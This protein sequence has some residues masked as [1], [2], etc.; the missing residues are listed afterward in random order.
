MAPSTNGIQGPRDLSI[1]NLD[2]RTLPGPQLLHELVAPPVADRLILDFLLS[3]GELVKL[4]YSCF[5]R[6]TDALARDIRA[7]LYREKKDKHV[8][9]VIIPQ[10][11]ELYIAWVAT[12]K[13]GAAFC[14]VSHDVPP[15]RLKF[16]VKDVD[17]SFVL[18]T[19]STLGRVQQLLPDEICMSLSFKE[20]SDRTPSG[21]SHGSALPAVRP[22][23]PAY[24]MYT[25]GS[26]GMPKGVMVS[27]L[28]VTQSL[29]AHDEHIPHF[30]RFLQF[31]S[32]TFDVSIFEVFFPFFRGATLVGCD[33]ERML[34]DL[35]ATIRLLDADAA[36]LTPTVAGTLLRR[37]DAAPCLKTLLTIGEMLTP[38]VVSE[39][40]GSVDKP[41]M[42]YAMYGPTEAAIHCTLAPKL[43]SNASVRSI[44]QPLQSVTAFILKESD[45][46][47]V[48]AL[49]E[50]G[51]LAIAG[52]LADGYLNRPDQ[53]RVAF[54]ELPG[55]GPIH[56][57]GDRA[58]CRP[59][60]Q[61]E[62]LGRLASGQVKLRGQR[63]ELGE[64][65]EV[66]SRTPGVQLAIA[67]IIDDNLVLFCSTSHTI[68]ASEILATCKSWLP[69][70]MRPNEIVVLQEDIPRL[71]SGKVDRKTLER[72]FWRP[73]KTKEDNNFINDTERNIAQVL[74]DELARKVDRSTS[75][76]SLGL[77][78]LRA[79][80]IA[81][82]LRQKHRSINAAM[83]LEAENVADLADLIT[84]SPP[85]QG[86]FAAES[87]YEDSESWIAI[88]NSLRNSTELADLWPAWEKVVPCSTMQVAMLVETSG[89][90][91][92]NFNEICL[93]L[94]PDVSFDAFVRAFGIVAERNEILRSGFMAT[95]EQAMPFVHIIWR[96]IPQGDL[97]ML[98]PLQIELVSTPEKEE[99]L[100]RVHHA[101]Y[102]GWSWELVMDDLNAILSGADIPLRT[103]FSAFRSF[104]HSLFSADSTEHDEYWRRHFEGFVPSSFPNLC[105]TRPDTPSK[106][107]LLIPLSTSYDQ[108]SVT[109]STLRCSREAILE[110]AWSFVLSSYLD[111]QDV[112]IGVV[113]AG[114]HLPLLGVESVI[115]PC[116][117]TFPLRTDLNS[118]RTVRDLVSFVQRQ[119]TGCLNYGNT[120]LRNINHAAGVRS[121][122][123]L[124]DTLCVW[125]QTSE[126]HE[127]A[128]SKVATIR[129][130]DALDYA[131]V[132][133]FE[134][135]NESIRLKLT[136][137][138]SLVPVAH[139]KLLAN[140]L[141]Y[142]ANEMV[143]KHD[144]GLQELWEKAGQG[145]L[146]LSNVQPERFS[147][148][149]GLTTTIEHLAE[150][151]PHRL[152]VEF[153]HSFNPDTGHVNKESLTYSHL[154]EKAS[155]VASA[156]RSK[157][158]VGPDD[159][160]AFIAPRSIEL[161]IGILGAIM[162]GAGY[163]C[164][165]PRTPMERIGH[166]IG[167][168]ACRLVLTGECLEIE[169][170]NDVPTLSIERVVQ[171]PSAPFMPRRLEYTGDQLAYA[172]FTSGSTGVPKGV[173]ITR[174]NLLSNL[175]DLSRLYPCIPGED[176]LL[177]ACSP[178]FDVSV[179]EIFW[180][181]HMGMTLC[182]ASNDVLFK[183]LERFIHVLTITH[184]SMTPSVAALVNPDA[185]PRVKLLVTAGEP[186]NSRVFADWADRG[187]FQGYGPSETTNICTVRPNVTRSSASNNAG[188]PLPN[189]SVF[190]CRRQ[191]RSQTHVAGTATPGDPWMFSPV[192]K[193]GTGEIWIGGEQVGRG[194]IDPTL[195]AKAF[196]DH[197]RYGRLYR[198]GDIGRLLSDESITILGRDDDQVKLRGQR[199]ELGEINSCLIKYEDVE[200][201]VSLIVNDGHSAR[202]VAFWT[203]HDQAR[204]LPLAKVTKALFE[205][206]Q[207]MLPS[208]MIPD[209]L[210][211]LDSIPLTRQ[212]KIDRAAM[213]EAYQKLTPEQLQEFSKDHGSSEEE[214]D[215][216]EEERH[217]A[218]AISSALE[219]PPEAIRRNTSFFALGMDSISAIRVARSLRNH[220]PAVEISMLLRHPS[221]GQLVLALK[222]AAQVE[223]NKNLEASFDESLNSDWKATV[224]AT[225]LQAGLIVDRVLPC[226]PLQE[227]MAS[228]S[229]DSH[230]SAY[231]NSLR[232]RIFSDIS[233]MREA[234]VHAVSRHQLLRTG[235]AQTGSADTPFVQV[236][237]KDFPLPWK[238]EGDHV[239][240]APDLPFLMYPPWRMTLSQ[241]DGGHQELDLQIHHCLYDAEAMSILLTEIQ[242]LLLGQE[243]QPAV[244]F[245]NYLS[246]VLSAQSDEVDQYWRQKLRGYSPSRLGEL[247]K[248]ED[249]TPTNVT[250]VSVH[251]ATLNVVELQN[252]AR[253][254]CSTPLALLQV[255]WTRLLFCLFD[256]HDICFGNVMSGRNLPI[257]GVDRVVAPCFNTVPVRVQVQ[258]ETSNV[259]LCQYIQQKNVE[260]LPYQPSSLRRIQRQNS[261]DSK[262]LFDTLL[263]FQGEEL[264]L[265]QQI[266]TLVEESGDM[267]FPFILEILMHG[268]TD[269]I[270]LKLHSQSANENV[271]AQLLDCF[272]A[273][274]LHTTRYLNARALDYSAF[275]PA[276]PQLKPLNSSAHISDLED[277]MQNEQ[278]AH[279]RNELSHTEALVRDV[280][281]QLKPD[282]K[283]NITKDTSIFRLGFDSI[284]AVQIAARLRQQGYTISSA[285]IL[286]AVTIHEI[287]TICKLQ[288]EA[289]QIPV[290]FDLAAFDRR[291][292]QT[293]CQDNQI[294][295]ALV[296][297]IR[298]CTPTQSGILSQFLRS[299]GRLYFNRIVF[300]LED[301][302]DPRRLRDAWAAAQN[303]HDMLRTGFVETDDPRIPFAMVTYHAGTVPVPWT[304][305]TINGN[306]GHSANSV[307]TSR[308]REHPWQLRFLDGAL[309]ALELSMLHSLYDAK[310][311]DIILRDVAYIYA[312]GRPPNPIEL[313]PVISDIVARSRDEGSRE[314]WV[315]M[316]PD[317][318]PTRFPDLRIYTNNEEHFHVACQAS[319]VPREVAEHACHRAGASMQAVCASA[320]ALLLSAYTA[321]DH[322]TFGIILSG[323]NFQQEEQ[324]MV[325]FPCINTLPFAIQVSPDLPGLLQRTSKRC[326]GILRHQHTSA[327]SIKRWTGIQEELF[328]TVIVLQKFDR[329]TGPNRPWSLDND[330][331]TAEYAVSL[332]IIPKADDLNFQLTFKDS[333]VPP[334]QASQILCEFDALFRSILD[335]R[336]YEPD[337]DSLK[338]VV[339]AKEERI[340]T[341]VRF[342]H[343]LV[344]IAATHKPQSIALEFV[345]S[346]DGDQPDKASWTYSEL[347]SNGNR[348]G[349]LLQSKG[350][351]AGELVA[352]CFDK[353]P[354]ASF[355]ILG[356]LKAGCG[357][358]AIDPG[359]PRARKDF[360]L[361]DSSCAIVLTTGDKKSEFPGDKITV[362]ALDEGM[363]LKFP[364]E[365][366]VPSRKLDPQDTCY[367]LY[368]SGTTGTPKGCLI[369][370]D[371][372]VQAMLSFQRI[373]EG[374]W[375]ETSRWLQFASFHFD[376][377]VLEQFW[378]WSVGI[379]VTSAPRDLL[380]ED[381]PGFISALK[382]THL[383]LTPSLARL[384]TPEEVPSLC[385]GVFIVGGE[386]VRQ[387]ILETWGDTH[388]L[389]NFYG[390]SEVTIGCTVHPQVPKNAKPTNIGQQWDNVT[391]FVLRP[392]SQ[393]PVLRGAVGELCLSGPLVGK[394]YLNRPEL[395]AERFVTLA[396]YKTGVY[397]T[398][399]LVRL[400]HDNSFEFMGRIDDQVKLRGQRLEVAEINHVILS[401]GSTL[402]DAVTMVIKH[403][404]QQKDQLVTFFSTEKRRAKNERP[405]I[406]STKDTKE[407]AR[408]LQQR[409]ADMLPAYMVPTYFI[410]VSSIPLSV[411]NKVDHKALRGLFED[412]AKDVWS[413]VSGDH[414]G[415]E[416]EASRDA[417]EVTDILASFLKV[418]TT[419]ITPSSGL[420]ELGLDS[421]SV[422]GLSRTLR[423]HGFKT[424]DVATILKQPTVRDLAAAVHRKS[425]FD[426]GEAVASARD[427]IKS[428]GAAHRR[429]IIQALSVDDKDIENV[430][431]CT[432][433]QE[434]MMSKA[435]CSEPGDTVYFSSFHFELNDKVDLKRLEEAWKL[436]QQSI[437]ILRTHFVPTSRGVAQVVLRQTHSG[438]AL[439]TAPSSHKLPCFPPKS[440]F[441][442]W[443]GSVKGF[444]AA[445]P[446]IVELL[447]SAGKAYMILNIF[448]GLYDGIS[449]SLLLDV[450]SRIYNHGHKNLHV[451]MQFYQILPYGPLC[452]MPNEKEFWVSKLGN[453]QSF[454]LLLPPSETGNEAAPIYLTQSISNTSLEDFCK[455]LDITTS[456]F[457]QAWWLY[458]LQQRYN[459]NPLIGVVVSGRALTEV[460]AEDVIGPMFNTIPFAI[461]HLKKDSTVSDLIRACHQYNVDVVPYQHSPLRRVAKYL[462]C[463]G[464]NDMFNSLFVFQKP[465]IYGGQGF[466]WH[467]LP[468][469]ST[470]DYPLN[471]EVEQRGNTFSITLVAKSG[472]VSEAGARALLRTYVECLQ[473]V[474]AT[475]SV[476][477][478][479]FC[480]SRDEP[481]VSRQNAMMGQESDTELNGHAEEV[482]WTEAELAIR[483]EIAGLASVEKETIGLYKPTLFELGLDS[484]EAMK[485]A[486][487]LKNVGLKVAV[488]TIMR[489]P[490]VAG[491]ANEI[492]AAPGCLHEES[493]QHKTGFSI[494]ESQGKYRQILQDHGL[495]VDSVQRILPVTPMQEGLLLESSKY[496][497]VMVFQLKPGVDLSRLAVAWERVSELEP[498]LRTHFA[499][500]EE[501]ELP[502]AFLQ[503]V[504]TKHDAVEVILGSGLAQL[505]KSMESEAAREDLKDQKPRICILSDDEGK[506]F[507]V[508]AMSHALYDAW[509]MHLLHQQVTNLYHSSR[510]DEKRPTDVQYESYVQQVINQ[511]QS[512]V[513]QRFW[514]NQLSDAKPTLLAASLPALDNS[515][516]SFLLQKASSNVTLKEALDFCKQQGVTLQSLG[517]ACWS[518]LLAH[519]LRQI[520]VCFGVVLSGRT[521]EGSEGLIF[522]TFNTVLFRPRIHEYS[523]KHEMLK[524]I[525]MAAVQV[526]EY[527]QFPLRDALRYASGQRPGSEFF[528]SLF[529]YQKLPESKNS[530][531][532]LYEETVSV[533]T[534]INPPYPFNIE[535]EA[536]GDVLVWT[537]AL[538]AGIGE[539][540]FGEGLL[541]QLESVLL[542]LVNAPEDPLFE[543]DQSGVSM[544]GLPSVQL[545]SQDDEAN[546]EYGKAK[547]QA[548][549][550][551]DHEVWTP[552]EATVREVLSQVSSTGLEKIKK[553][554]GIFHLGLDSVSAI[555][556][557]GLLK[558][559]GL[560]LPVSEI[561]TAQTVEKM[562]EA[563]DKLQVGNVASSL[564]TL[565][566]RENQLVYQAVIGRSGIPAD[567]IEDVLPCTGGQIYML[568]M[569]SA[570]SGRWSYPQ[571]WLRV[572]NM[573]G[574][575]LRRAFDKLV[576]KVPVLRT[577]FVNLE[578]KHGREETL[579]VVLNSEAV[580]RYRFPWL[581]QIRE[582]GKGAL[583][584]VLRL[585]HAL[586]DA[587]SLQLI[588]SALQKLCN[589]FDGGQ[590][591][592]LQLNTS[593][594]E[595]VSR[596]S[597]AWHQAAKEFWTSYL[598][599][600]GRGP[601]LYSFVKPGAFDSTRI[602]RFNA[603]VL[604][605][606]Q[607]K[608]KLRTQG[609]SLQAYFFAA[610]ATVYSAMLQLQG[611]SSDRMVSTG[612]V[613]MGIY[614]ANRSLDIDGL[615]ELIAPTFNVVPLRV[616]VR[617]DKSLIDTALQIQ[618]DLAEISRAEHCGVSMRDIYA[619]TNVKIDTYVNFLSLPADSN[620]D[621]GDSAAFDAREGTESLSAG[622][623]AVQVRHADVD[624][625]QLEDTE[626][627]SPFLKDSAQHNHTTG[628][629]LPAIDIEAKVTD[630][631]EHLGIGIFAPSDMLS[632]E[633]VDYIMG[634]IRSLFMS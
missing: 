498:I 253:E 525:H 88:E 515:P 118:L 95:G 429:T 222:N 551:R 565:V 281:M 79:F 111:S 240:P 116:L 378:S 634:Q 344:E 341:N 62:I 499:D 269:V 435:L 594:H 542:S 177:Q 481:A 432:P 438:V 353:C 452:S 627:V 24:V 104:Q 41:S 336:G 433:L 505:V 33:R 372:A 300:R 314:F 112:A 352:V 258:K 197:P 152:A 77:D 508:L 374:R 195:T 628:W 56:R 402:K 366:P 486:A 37:R 472:S 595:F 552:K 251:K 332:E 538:Q 239:E 43:A 110:A 106:D 131:L 42:L 534:T 440:S 49:G 626:P 514:S 44:G 474:K 39:F 174:K 596:T 85:V 592:Q 468:S 610:Y 1:V 3:H 273:V 363:W 7:Q 599:S 416:G 412:F 456:A 57:T 382:I 184:L 181:W 546:G 630:D 518:I 400:L 574:S 245:D 437:S 337:L 173:L 632:E 127:H 434:G 393:E 491:I 581:W 279:M 413:S 141:D 386:Q 167:E 608:E 370:H 97:S 307:P 140:Q 260:M 309:P 631:D 310:S 458:V 445:L 115:G 48:A 30:K 8:I 60:G 133:E 453:A 144:L 455:Q 462:G 189:T 526:S 424:S 318:C 31:A 528:D 459:V 148:K 399:D 216:S 620:S 123:R 567:D 408:H 591:Q 502:T 270:T 392:T 200:D 316:L 417:K 361:E 302:I 384:L 297:A 158:H 461:D 90:E 387:D 376:V 146:S 55:Y 443:V 92:L 83:L 182:T 10:C 457:F 629:C 343:E 524:G 246:F 451:G 27:H 67:S 362:L 588:V 513:S 335:L 306:G 54:V 617:D 449:V 32:P 204:S 206:L 464:S 568:D 108:V 584:L 250:S 132:L 40:G 275:A 241:K 619:W 254:S 517:L 271:L 368:T 19:S 28:S 15:E 61:L 63:V 355:A 609:I 624:Q 304:E 563:A 616:C 580:G 403:P 504:T 313:D 76:W 99:V 572:T 483:D 224:T 442:A 121:E 147:E 536:Q 248:N 58:I 157:F 523:T 274:L 398:G 623:K 411:N 397:R 345:T 555:K 105:S 357:Y 163:L 351:R 377:S 69:S 75:L 419:S 394:G 266:W 113:F 13:A 426:H 489:S 134:P 242:A 176:R 446:W 410:A 422:I 288:T 175:E 427:R 532:S 196:F 573:N 324:N 389:Y 346:L 501:P 529:T 537:L 262:P 373:F 263:L 170:P 65:E 136:F 520:D 150:A 36:E 604:A 160:V 202:L 405:L 585:H 463:S 531:Q 535:F 564:K 418:P 50:S 166:I 96:T 431:P 225:Y 81:A 605:M 600:N 68:Q 277:G 516:P 614:L 475:K 430:A 360:I 548:E 545:S 286:E 562:A 192:P 558:R 590:Q 169:I 500:T 311:L 198:S 320:W 4:D 109:A 465:R 34:S 466:L 522:P 570:S 296:Q 577:T 14:P 159:L 414:P 385:Q 301:A 298:P 579:Q 243:L 278:H 556:V 375:D 46:L 280:L 16:I 282:I 305:G 578:N 120:T 261:T 467:E 331:A 439:V 73:R 249:R 349:H 125:Q 143:H 333:V 2:R 325:V 444:S 460:N 137:D 84:R 312:A 364:A 553:T 479:D 5:H 330:D 478:E 232:F 145:L 576:K 586:Y 539:K 217:V 347:D 519:H 484:I 601:I 550:N 477:P 589:D 178:A 480:D 119:R 488:S 71:P 191:E 231:Q 367:C 51:E 448:H 59:D 154:Y 510:D 322:V 201:A 220:F 549:T 447:E 369:S 547:G 98:R 359:A 327:T 211:R 561:I 283:D 476:L 381:L 291:Y 615:T 130:R 135:H 602:E 223:E 338:S 611:H 126:G 388:C 23:G 543:N 209:S 503:Y 506:S 70:Y 557:A 102:D 122:K 395:T 180:T 186:M 29:L 138:T 267:P 315:G 238:T 20:L 86:L 91:N 583:L 569:C 53:N 559:K 512:P 9:P 527:Q 149:F 221:I 334:E 114:R 264:E 256:K 94:A 259:E 603:R 406:V 606:G 597:A 285:D 215:L 218:H 265:D 227:A 255:C 153:V 272:D 621:D 47:E 203:P 323:R 354:E 487:R 496:L 234:W 124:F 25:S 74:A 199:I 80:K 66:A 348:I 207:V 117:S 151:D 612:D 168:S 208:Y 236:V 162:S 490:T 482:Q 625:N 492:N 575:I 358:V 497:N 420:F 93:G 228:S 391:S 407:L 17:A 471:M 252:S 210:I 165:D 194:Y 11:P 339:P 618:H 276:L 233:R 237:L 299:R 511:A 294:N 494:A 193:G 212:G 284:S 401:T 26:T 205:K 566:P 533:E 185:V 493:P 257:E 441:R 139:A 356:A 21:E 607:I 89:N 328:D 544:C 100:I 365:P 172:V 226:T 473:D 82:N 593:M 371:S 308:I 571:F 183:D 101:L 229:L 235:F 507:L 214:N 52:Q 188:F 470:P 340:K 213:V 179:F 219:V 587:V 613:V 469:Q 292:R 521:T 287:A 582:D 321:Q 128:R 155:R 187:L 289:S 390:P 295:E 329:E 190:V 326:A 396:E 293:I 633:Q 554:T 317:L 87:S 383:D 319:Q 6:L 560:R 530:I 415:Q 268:S 380:F 161:Y 598:K 142:I 425:T 541:Q 421:I 12:L 22:S 428:F 409:C 350:A 107:Y 78:S 244:P 64:I 164:I 540:M 379:T 38:H 495:V 423:K 72:D 454:S 103:Q 404:T 230:S 18:T 436:A 35:P 156:L 485:L 290:G 129:T 247:I 342:L 622:R 45:Q 171:Q 450:V 303:L 509:S